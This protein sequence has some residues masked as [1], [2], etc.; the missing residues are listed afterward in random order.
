M[1]DNIKNLFLLFPVMLYYFVEALFVGIFIS[2]V[3]NV[4]LYDLFGVHITYFQ[5]VAIIWIIKVLIFDIFKLLAS[6]ANL[7]N[8]MKNNSDNN[9][10]MN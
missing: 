9:I 10:N 8:F 4:F 7:G 3:W 5:W 6:F 1:I 2:L